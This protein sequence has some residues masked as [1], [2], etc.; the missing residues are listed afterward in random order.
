LR[1]VDVP[2]FV[3]RWNG[4]KRSTVVPAMIIGKRGSVSERKKLKTKT[5]F[6]LDFD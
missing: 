5:V 6:W 4:P 2:G 3:W 1:K